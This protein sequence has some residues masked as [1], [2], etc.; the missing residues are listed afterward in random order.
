MGN[1][2]LKWT[3]EEEEALLAGIRKHGP[4]KWKNILRD[5]EFADQLIHRSNI[6]LKV[7]LFFTHLFKITLVE[8]YI[9]PRHRI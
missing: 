2:K 3:A 5:P 6:D 8:P 9:K 1:Q 7:S 4:G